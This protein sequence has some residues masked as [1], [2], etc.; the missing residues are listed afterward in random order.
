VSETFWG[1]SL[2]EVEEPPSLVLEPREGAGIIEYQVEMITCN[3]IPGLL[4]ASVRR[5]DDLFSIYYHIGGY[6]PLGVYLKKEGI[7]RDQFILLVSQLKNIFREIKKFFLTP[8]S[9]ILSERHIYTKEGLK[10][11]ALLYLPADLRQDIDTSLRDLLLGIIARSGDAAEPDMERFT[12]SIKEGGVSINNLDRLLMEFFTQNKAFKTVNLPVPEVASAPDLTE[13]QDSRRLKAGI[14]T[15]IYAGGALGAAAFTMAVSVAGEKFPGVQVAAGLLLALGSAGAVLYVFLR[16]RATGE[17]GKPE[18]RAPR[19]K[20][21]Q[22]YPQGQSAG[23]APRPKKPG[24]GIFVPLVYKKFEKKIEPPPDQKG[25][26]G[27]GGPVLRISREDKEEIIFIDKKEFYIGRSD[28]VADFSDISDDG[29]ERIHAK[30]ISGD[31]GYQIMDLDSEK[32]TYVNG[33]RIESR[34]PHLLNYK[35][36]IVMAGLELVFDQG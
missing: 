10:E 27:N 33:K 12:S 36:V 31:T 16:T 18:D 28:A 11:I 35:D 32:G 13:L 20:E 21:A 9:I 24:A 25:F 4:G 14:R 17:G 26:N 8:N 5:R 29:V 22:I 2:L 1:F 6:I 23:P 34:R 7:T 15:G 30:I 19:S 3:S